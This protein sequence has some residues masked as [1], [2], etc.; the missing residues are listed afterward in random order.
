ME[1]MVYS[2]DGI[3]KVLYTEERGKGYRLAVLNI[4]G[5]HPCAYVQFPGIEEL[6]SYDDLYMTV[7]DPHGG[8]TYLGDLEQNGLTGI[9]I[10]WD[11]AHYGDYTYSS[12]SYPVDDYGEKKYTTEEVVEEAREILFWIKRG[13]FKIV[14]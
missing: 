1:Q 12:F 3:S 13:E 14:K 4:R 9:W 10:G 7:D 2:G 6:E 8:F 11:Y 5:S